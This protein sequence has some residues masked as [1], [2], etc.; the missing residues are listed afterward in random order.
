MIFDGP[1]GTGKT[2]LALEGARREAINGRRVVLLCF[3]ELLADWLREEA[4]SFG[5]PI[6]I[7]T[8][9]SLLLE[10]AD[11][12][13]NQ[14]DSREFWEQNCPP[15]RWRSCWTAAPNG[16][17]MSSSSTRRRTCCGTV[18]WMFWNV[19]CA[20]A[21]GTVAGGYS[22]ISI[23][24]RF[25]TAQSGAS[26]NSSGVSRR[27]PLFAAH[28]LRKPPRI[29]EFVDLL[30]HPVPGYSKALRPNTGA[31][32]EDPLLLLGE[33]S[34]ERPRANSVGTSPRRLHRERNCRAVAES[35]IVRCAGLA[36]WA[37]RAPGTGREPSIGGQDWLRHDPC[38]Q[39]P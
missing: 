10:I 27:D 5:V 13:V 23:I 8:L 12:K 28:Q 29:I 18:S 25:T 33:S 37:I 11:M 32:H 4:Q 1:A 19:W 24:K 16:H 22:A 38:V 7:R 17:S 21:G 34:A 35:K 2:V 30:A 39:G 20:M 6:T 26:V 15:A 31:D 9:R 3:N 36:G 14:S